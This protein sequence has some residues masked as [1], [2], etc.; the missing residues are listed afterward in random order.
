MAHKTKKMGILVEDLYQ[1]LELWYPLL[2]F[3]EAGLKVVVVGPERKE[4]VSKLGYPV[5][6]DTTMGEVRGE[7]FDALI[8]PGG[9]APDRMRRFGEMV[10][11]VRETH[12]AGRI[13]AAICH[14]GWMLASADIVRDRTLTC[15]YAIRDDLVNAGAHYVDQEV[16]RDGNIITSRK[17]EDLPAFCRCI[18]DALE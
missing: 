10:N 16:V 15:Y 5:L 9:Y 14:G 7:D 17:P 3:R 2:R 11:L 18:L 4:Y 13:V 8:I 1:E 12:R 6:A